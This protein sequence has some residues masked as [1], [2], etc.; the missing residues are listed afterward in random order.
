MRRE[1]ARKLIA[2]GMTALALARTAL[3]PI[4]ARRA[5]ER[6]HIALQSFLALHLASHWAMLRFALHERDVGEA[7]GQCLRLLLTPSGAVS[8]HLPSGNT[9]RSNVSAFR[10]N[11]VIA[12]TEPAAFPKQLRV[13]TV[14]FY[15]R[16][17]L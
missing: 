17:V 13:A 6:A 8:G 11:P 16:R 2:E 15:R 14:G 12:E 9:G 10:S 5:L 7:L 3:D 1:L 4:A